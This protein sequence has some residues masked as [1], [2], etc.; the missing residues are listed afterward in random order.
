MMHICP[1][2]NGS[3]DDIL[4]A[5]RRNWPKSVMDAFAMAEGCDD[6]LE[7]VEAVIARSLAWE[8]AA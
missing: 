4:H 8:V 6:C 2:C 1:T 5:L 3:R 7:Y